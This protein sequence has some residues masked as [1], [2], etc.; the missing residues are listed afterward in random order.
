MAVS[1]KFFLQNPT[2]FNKKSEINT[3]VLGKGA[4]K[5]GK[6]MVFNQTGGK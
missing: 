5:S 4:K 2:T 6:S 1:I 3:Q